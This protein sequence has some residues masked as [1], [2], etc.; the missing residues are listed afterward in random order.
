MTNTIFMDYELYAEADELTI[1]D[2]IE[3]LIYTGTELEDIEHY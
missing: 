1:D 3:Y 2:I